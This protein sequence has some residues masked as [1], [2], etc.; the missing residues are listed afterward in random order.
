MLKLKTKIYFRADGNSRI[1]LG[2]VMRSLALLNMLKSEF[3]CYFIIRRPISRLKKIIQNICERV[4]E[5][6]EFQYENLEAEYISKTFLEMGD[7]VVLDGYNFRTSYQQIIKKKGCKLVCIDDIYSYHFVADAIINHAGGIKESYYSKEAYTQMFLGLDYAILGEPFL[8]AAKQRNLNGER[9]DNIFICLGGA[10][11]NNDTI[12]VLKK[13]EALISI[14]KFFVV[15][16]AAYQYKEEL[17]FY[18]KNTR[19]N[20]E[21]LRS[22]STM[23]M[24][25]YMKRCGTAITPPSTIAYEYLSVGG[26]LYLKVIA[27]NQVQ[28][29]KYFLEEHLAFSFDQ[30]PI[31]DI[32]RL[33]L[34]R[35]RQ[36]Q[37]LNGDSKKRLVNIFQSIC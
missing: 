7:I 6:P 20:I 14:N 9:R 12:E 21:L 23:E 17:E 4:I 10:D 32:E 16:G 18:L 11:P 25:F 5:I 1:G 31:V 37:Q 28:I 33:D 13:C 24:I 15:I 22:L 29:N 2:H 35:E 30:F 3:Q 8:K 19:L 34:A 26:N 27:E 36:Q